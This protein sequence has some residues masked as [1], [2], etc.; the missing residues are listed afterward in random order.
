MTK[1]LIMN[2]L[3]FRIAIGL[4]ILVLVLISFVLK[5]DQNTKEII[6]GLMFVIYV[7]IVN[8]LRM[9]YLDWEVR[10]VVKAM[11]PFHSMDRSKS[12]FFSKKKRVHN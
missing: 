1:Y 10:D 6:T 7:P 9:I 3:A 2:R 4:A 8:V 5:V 12:L 11:N